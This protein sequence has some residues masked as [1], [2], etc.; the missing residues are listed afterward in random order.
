M[1]TF[2]HSSGKNQSRNQSEK[3][4]E[5]ENKI[6]H[7]ESSEE[8]DEECVPNQFSSLAIGQMSNEKISQKHYWSSEEV[9]NCL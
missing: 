2:K 5:E 8:K 1:S 4:I 9:N 3:D 6:C 7:S